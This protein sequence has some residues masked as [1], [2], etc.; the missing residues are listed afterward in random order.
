MSIDIILKKAE[1]LAYKYH[2]GQKRWDGSPYINHPVR[3]ANSLISEHKKIVALLH[4]VIED[5]YVTA[6]DLIKEGIPANLV[7]TVQDLSR[8]P[9]ESYL[10]FILRL[11]M[12]SLAVDVK[13]ADL[14]DNL[15]DLKPGSLRDK[16]LLAQYILKK[17]QK[18]YEQESYNY[19]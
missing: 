5:T 7:K 10:D 2:N 14:E 15:R 13:L 12:N 17:T 19:R 3:V 6:D 1:E 18:K 8:Q 11:S 16:Y 9:E 4:D